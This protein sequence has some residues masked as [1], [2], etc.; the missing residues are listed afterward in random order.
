M[1]PD[2]KEIHLFWRNQTHEQRRITWSPPEVRRCWCHH[3]LGWDRPSSVRH[4]GRTLGFPWG[5]AGKV[6]EERQPSSKAFRCGTYNSTI[7]LEKSQ[8]SPKAI[9]G[10]ISSASVREAESPA[11]PRGTFQ[12]GDPELWSSRGIL[13]QDLRLLRKAGP[14]LSRN[15]TEECLTY[16]IWYRIIWSLMSVL[17]TLTEGKGSNLT[18]NI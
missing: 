3:T 11:G 2:L 16:L 18:A 10:M 13:W 15:A 8:H 17:I 6:P 7:L 12:Q 4:P 9:W 1:G 5:S 14:A